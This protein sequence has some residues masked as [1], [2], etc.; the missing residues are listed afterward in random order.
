MH[1]HGDCSPEL[2]S[3]DWEVLC[4]KDWQVQYIDPSSTVKLHL[5][6]PYCFVVPPSPNN[7]RLQIAS[8]THASDLLHA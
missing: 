3:G 7:D 8:Y 2:A 4:D 6:P 1:D 5:L